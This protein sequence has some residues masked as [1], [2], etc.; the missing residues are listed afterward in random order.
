MKLEEAAAI[1]G[2]SLDDI[3]VDSLKQTYK[4]LALA[5]DPSKVILSF[6]IKLWR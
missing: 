3:T 4:K 5:W 2:V 1:L 6:H